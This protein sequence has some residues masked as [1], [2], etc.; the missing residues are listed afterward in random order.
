MIIVDEL[1]ELIKEFVIIRILELIK[2]HC[3]QGDDFGTA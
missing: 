1:T 3:R 2:S